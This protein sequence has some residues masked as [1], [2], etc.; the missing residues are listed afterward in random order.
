M[1]IKQ[2][3]VYP[4]KYIPKCCRELKRITKSQFSTHRLDVVSPVEAT[5]KNSSQIFKFVDPRSVCAF[6]L[7]SVIVVGSAKLIRIK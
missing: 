3:K 1:R 5:V 4:A 7:S 2:G 6:T